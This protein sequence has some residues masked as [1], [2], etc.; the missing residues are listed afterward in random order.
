MSASK[1]TRREKL[2]TPKIAISLLNKQRVARFGSENFS[3]IWNSFKSMALK[4][5]L[6]EQSPRQVPRTSVP[7]F[8]EVQIDGTNSRKG[9]HQDFIQMV[10]PRCKP[11][12][13]TNIMAGR[14][15]IPAEASVKS[16]TLCLR[17][18]T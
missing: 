18:E 13:T 6:H 4:R 15:G 7:A 16:G 5:E 2:Q 10:M 1:S 11:G 3:P 12:W 9:M 17:T 8:R 14:D